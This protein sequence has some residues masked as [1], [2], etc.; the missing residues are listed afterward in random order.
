MIKNFSQKKKK[1][2]K[3][4]K[5][6]K[7]SDNILNFSTL[8]IIIKAPIIMRFYRKGVNMKTVNN[9]FFEISVNCLAKELPILRKMVGLTQK[10][11]GEILGVS[12]QTITN[13]ESG[14][15][16]MKWSLFLAAMFVFSLD[17]TTSEY[18]K[19]RDIPYQQLK[20]WLHEKHR[21]ER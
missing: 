4:P 10:D 11:L 14:T 7:N 1:R 13:I 3:Y 5:N 9:D 12:R 6:E 18:L 16:K 15:S 17:Q 2:H 19:T 21:E 20:E 8:R